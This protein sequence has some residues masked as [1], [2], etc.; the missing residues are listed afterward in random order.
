MNTVNKKSGCLYV[1][2]TPIGNLADIS[3]RAIETLKSVDLVLAE[4]CRT[5][6]K[7][8]TKFGINCQVGSYHDHNELK[9]Y[10]SVTQSISNGT[11]V[12]LI[13][14]A[15]TPAIS[16]PGYRLIN[17]CQ[18]AGINI[19]PVPG[20]CA[21]IA[22]L[23]VCG[24]EIETFKFLGFLPQKSGKRK[25]VILEALE[26]KTTSV[27]YE[28]PHR[29]IKVLALIAEIAPLCRIFVGRELTKLYEETFRGTANECLQFFSSKDKQR[30]E[31]VVILARY[32]PSEVSS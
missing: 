16:D 13:S 1:V 20:A 15:G 19:I 8:Q 21:A 7:L 11:N 32:H 26:S 28:S 29:I 17:A 24:F 6:K 18:E 2:A 31:F 14:E 12:A 27:F 4:D 5:F 25:A 9:K 23:S 10:Q 22:A 30:G 3:P